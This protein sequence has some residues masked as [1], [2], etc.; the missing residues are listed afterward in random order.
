MHGLREN[1][2][3]GLT[4]L[5]LTKGYVTSE[6]NKQTLKKW[7]EFGAFASVKLIMQG[8]VGETDHCTVIQN[9]L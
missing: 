4:F 1:P 3:L 6:P 8:W 2:S 5:N 9:N 7:L